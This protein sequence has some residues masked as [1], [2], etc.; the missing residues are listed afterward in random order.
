MNLTISGHHLEVSPALREYVISKLERV[1]RHFDQVIHVKVL[2]SKH[3]E[4]QKERRQRVECSIHVK[5][6]ALHAGSKHLNLYA[7]IDD[8][9]EKLDRQI[10]SHKTRIHGWRNASIKR[11]LGAIGLH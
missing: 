1:L 9:V 7:A 8:L 10:M 3:N 4:A 6:N 5:G 11:E 2:L